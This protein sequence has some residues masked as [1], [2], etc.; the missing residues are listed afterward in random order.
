MVYHVVNKSIAKFQI[1]NHESDYLRMMATICY[2]QTSVLRI[3]LSNFL[4]LNKIKHVVL[5]VWFTNAHVKVATDSKVKC[6]LPF[7]SREINKQTRIY[8]IQK[9]SDMPVGTDIS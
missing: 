4:Q 3:A 6:T 9:V 7:S 5:G 8:K 2:Y 1:F